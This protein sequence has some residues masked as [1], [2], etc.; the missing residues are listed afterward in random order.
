MSEE[1]NAEYD[2]AVPVERGCGRRQAGGIYLEV[3]L[4]PGGQPTEHFLCDPPVPLDAAQIGLAPQGVILFDT[5][6]GTHVLDWVGSV[7]YPNVA[8]FVEEVRRFGLS[9]RAQRNIDF[10]R[11]APGASILLAHSRAVIADP[12]P[13]YRQWSADHGLAPFPCPKG[14]ET[15]ANYPVTLASVGRATPQCTCAGIWWQDIEDGKSAICD[16]QHGTRCH[17]AVTRT[18]PSFGY[19]GHAPADGVVGAYELGIFMR[20]P[21]SRIVVVNDPEGGTHEQ[22]MQAASRS[23]LPIALVE[24]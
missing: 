21:L 19:S 2:V 1:R 24:E 6:K 16:S 10:S 17:S 9:R 22:A 3:G 4:A 23:G 14:N 15:H 13:Y 7:F 20:L 5:H 18:M 8:D 12:L 11:L